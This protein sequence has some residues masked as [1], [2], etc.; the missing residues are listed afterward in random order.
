[1]KK[2]WVQTACENA[3]QHNVG[4]KYWKIF[5]DS[6]NDANSCLKDRFLCADTHRVNIFLGNFVYKYIRVRVC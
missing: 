3:V 2:I 4:G 6:A 5:N 1:M